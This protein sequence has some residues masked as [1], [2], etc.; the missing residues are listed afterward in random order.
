VRAE[1][2]LAQT[3]R[4][5]ASL[6]EEA[7]RLAEIRVPVDGQAL[8]NAFRHQMTFH[9]LFNWEHRVHCVCSTPF[10]IR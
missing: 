1:E 2:A 6:D 10:G 3:R 5:L 8:T 4:T 7:R 9:F